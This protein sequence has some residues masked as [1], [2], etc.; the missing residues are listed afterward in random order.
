MG[1]LFMCMY[2][3]YVFMGVYLYIFI[4]APKLDLFKYFLYVFSLCIFMGV[5]FMCFLYF[6]YFKYLFF[7]KKCRFIVIHLGK[8]LID[9][10]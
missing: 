10:I 3:I 4:C 1:V 5:F 2:Y 8:L 9:F 6:V 7:Y